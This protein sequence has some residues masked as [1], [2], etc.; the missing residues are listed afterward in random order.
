M[1]PT[2]R[3]VIA[4]AEAWLGTP[5]R[6]QGRRRGVGCDCLGLV[7]GVWRDLHGRPPPAA[8]ADYPEDWP[9]AGEEPLLAAARRHLAPLDA[10]LTG[11]VLVL[12]LQRPAAHLAILVADDALIHAY[13]GAGV[14]RSPFAAPWRRRLAGAFFW[15]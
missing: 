3:Q 7:L 15:P 10:P 8:P 1:A 14:V 9:A 11:A 6:H 13:P 12:R 2:A 4:A 5:Y